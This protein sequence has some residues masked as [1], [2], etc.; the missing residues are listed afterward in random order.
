[1]EKLFMRGVPGGPVIKRPPCNARDVGSIPSLRRFCRSWGNSARVPQLLSPHSGAQE[2]QWE[3]RALKLR[4]S[5]A[6]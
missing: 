4:L 1:M 3:N 5:A 6:K 2:P